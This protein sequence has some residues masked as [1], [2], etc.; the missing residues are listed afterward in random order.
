[1]FSFVN[2]IEK[3]DNSDG[4]SMEWRGMRAGLEILANIVIFVRDIGRGIG[5][6][7]SCRMVLKLEK[8]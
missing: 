4:R 6:N 3:G 5:C 7:H 8:D 2:G 1:M